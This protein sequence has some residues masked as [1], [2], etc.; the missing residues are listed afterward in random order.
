MPNLLEPVHENLGCLTENISSE[1]EMRH[2][3][4]LCCS[5]ESGTAHVSAIDRY[6]ICHLAGCMVFFSL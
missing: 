1:S 3:L 2:K 5:A 4:T 6:G